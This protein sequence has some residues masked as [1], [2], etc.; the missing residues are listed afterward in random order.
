MAPNV[1]TTQSTRRGPKRKNRN[2]MSFKSFES[3]FD[4]TPDQRRAIMK[5]QK[6]DVVQIGTSKR[7]PMHQVQRYEEKCLKLSGVKL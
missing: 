3:K 1:T 7:L 2:Y 6:F 4:I 5:E